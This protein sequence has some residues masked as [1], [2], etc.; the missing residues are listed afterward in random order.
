MITFAQG[1]VTFVSMMDVDV[2][3]IL[4]YLK[5][6]DYILRSLAQLPETVTKPVKYI[7]YKLRMSMA[8]R[9]SDVGVQDFRQLAEVYESEIAA[10]PMNGMPYFVTV[11]I[12]REMQ[13]CLQNIP[14]LEARLGTL[15]T[16]LPDR[17]DAPNPVGQNGFRF[18]MNALC[19]PRPYRAGGYCWDN[20]ISGPQ[21]TGV[22]WAYINR[23]HI[24]LDWKEI[25]PRLFVVRRDLAPVRADISRV[26]AAFASDRRVSEGHVRK[27][28]G[29]KS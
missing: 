4:P 18:F 16:R 8:R 28:L 12:S 3:L 9:L 26:L 14:D 25:F 27:A 21:Y 6:S 1:D 7:E 22:E 10:K 24:G 13:E 19:H 20:L 17:Y 15:E 23:N 29:M 2:N 11:G 5:Y